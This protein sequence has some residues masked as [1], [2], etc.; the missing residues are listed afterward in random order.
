MK[1]LDLFSGIGGFALATEMVW[2]D[3]EHIFCDID[4]FCQSVLKKHWP[5]SK[6]YE[7][8][9]K[10]TGQQIEGDIDLL[11]GGFPCQPFSAAGRRKGTDDNRYLWPEMLRVIR[12]THP[13]W[14]IGENVGGLLTWDGGVVLDRVFADLEAEDYEVGA[15][16]IPAVSVNAPHRRDRVWI[17]AHDISDSKGSAYGQEFGFGRRENSN[18]RKGNKVRGDIT[19]GNLQSASDTDDSGNGTSASGDKRDWQEDSEEREHS[20]YGIGGSGEVTPDTEKSRRERR[21]HREHREHTQLQEGLLGRD[22]WRESWLSAVARLCVMDDGLPG[23]LVRPRGWRNASLKAA[24][25][26]IV[27]QVAAEI[28]KGIKE[29]DNQPKTH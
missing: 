16:V 19:D 8:I 29:I 13:R 14:I 5:K 21:E 2:N 18:E 24:G 9:K 23:G 4:L 15:F 6:I 1:H 7:D 28:M 22:A 3:V 10:L 12:E 17:V 20:Q 25:N 26:A 11:T 27:P